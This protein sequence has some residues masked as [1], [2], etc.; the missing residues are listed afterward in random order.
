MSL[1]HLSGAVMLLVGLGAPVAW[2]GADSAFVDQVPATA[3]VQ[4]ATA[5]QAPRQLAELMTTARGAVECNAGLCHS[6]SEC[7]SAAAAE[8]VMRAE[9][10]RGRGRGGR[11]RRGSPMRERRRSP[12][13]SPAR[14]GASQA[15][16]VCP[17]KG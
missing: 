8:D 14:V 5:V 13:C 11:F 3:R 10:G 7:A 12:P 15:A 2:A 4:T 1:G 16:D 9:Q 6:V 17:V